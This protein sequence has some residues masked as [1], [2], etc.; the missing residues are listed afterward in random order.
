M[1]LPA[2]V[3]RL[4][5]PMQFPLAI[6]VKVLILAMKEHPV[7]ALVVDNEIKTKNQGHEGNLRDL[8]LLTTTKN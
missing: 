8:F 5:T 1:A 6:V 7:V 3:S 2:V 4:L